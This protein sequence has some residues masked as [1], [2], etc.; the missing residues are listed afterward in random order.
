[1]NYLE[2]YVIPVKGIKEGVYDFEFDVNK[3]F[4]EHF[5][6]LDVKNAKVKV[7]VNLNYK[8]S[9]FI[10]KIEII[11]YI[12]LICDI[13]LD[14]YKQNIKC[15]NVLY[16]SENN[17]DDSEYDDNFIKI[18]NTSNNVN[19]SNEIYEFIV[20]NVPIKHEHPLDKEGNRTCNPEMLERLES[21]SKVIEQKEYIDPRW[22]KLKKIKNG[23]S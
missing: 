20:L 22:E 13:C 2:Q 11:G 1:M 4:F 6:V 12:S 15:E 10:F 17:K 9:N 14:E 5:D 7:N 16:A 3:K 18:L 8:N 23:T 21:F 19:L